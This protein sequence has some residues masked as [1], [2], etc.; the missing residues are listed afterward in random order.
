MKAEVVFVSLFQTNKGGKTGL[1][2]IKLD[3]TA[4]TLLISIRQASS[5]SSELK[6]VDLIEIL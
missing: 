1:C 5:S 6:S 3:S 4:C 2:L